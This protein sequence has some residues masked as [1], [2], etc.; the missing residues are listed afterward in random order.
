MADL[1]PS[2]SDVAGPGSDDPRVVGLD[3]DAADDLL[4]AL[5]SRTA[6]RILAELHEEPASPAAL[7]DRIESSLQNT[8]YHLERLEDA[9]LVEVGDTVYSEKGREMKVYV[10]ADRALVV[11]AGRE[12]ETTG[13]KATLRRLLG[14]VG[15][16]GVASL[17]VDR[18]L[19][20]PTTRL[21][22][23]GGADGGGAGGGM[24]GGAAPTSGDAGSGSGGNASGDAGGTP[25][26]SADVDY[27][28]GNAT[29]TEDAVET[30]RTAGDAASTAEPTAA[31]T[32]TQVAES[33]ETAADSVRSTPTPT[34]DAETTRTATETAVDAVD[35]TMVDALAASPGLIFFLGGL[36]ALL[37]VLA[38]RSA[39]R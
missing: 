14:G 24:D 3:S 1:L 34:L 39:S 12:E 7:A 10:P 2:T 9:G 17:V 13:L 35:P 22:A 15:V 33:T 31:P 36:T 11:V 25:T 37:F 6:R 4:S 8:Q 28:S 32:S 23:T 18:V 38:A 27:Q 21:F 29:V 19:G 20:G 26:S 16:L 5:S 30:T